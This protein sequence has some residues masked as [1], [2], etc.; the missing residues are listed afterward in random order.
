MIPEA[1]L[2]AILIILFVA[3]FISAKTEERKWFN[4]LASVLLLANTVV[5]MLQLQPEDAFGGMYVTS[6]A[7][8]VMKAILAFGTFIV[9]LQSR[10]WAEKS[11]KEGEFYMLV[12]STLLGMEV[13]MSAGNFLMFFLGL[14]MASVPMACVIAFDAYRNNSAEA[15]A[16]FNA[17]RYQLP[18]WSLRHD[19]L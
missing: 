1:S 4:P 8:N 17:L 13:M 16:K 2:V 14:E 5:C 9:V 3:D 18:L 10:V 11:G 15:A 6:T 19:V 12:V 7:V